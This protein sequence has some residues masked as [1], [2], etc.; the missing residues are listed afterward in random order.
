MDKSGWRTLD[1]E[2]TRRGSEIHCPPQ[3]H[4]V[5]QAI[6]AP[7]SGAPQPP[8][9][10]PLSGD[11]SPP[12]DKTNAGPESNPPDSAGG[13]R[14]V[15]IFVLHGMGQQVPFSTLDQVSDK[16]QAVNGTPGAPLTVRSVRFDD[17]RWLRR[18]ELILKPNVEVHLYEGYWAPFTEG[19]VTLRQVI[20]F[21]FGAA[22]NGMRHGR[23]TFCRWMFGDYRHF[24]PLGR[25]T[26]YLLIAAAALCSLLILDSTI[27]LVSAALALRAG[28]PNWLSKGLLNDLT[29]VVN[30]VLAGAAVGVLG[31]LFSRALTSARSAALKAVR[32]ALTVIPFALFLAV[33]IL[34][35][36][37]LIALP[38]GHAKSGKA[39]S[40]MPYF[41]PEFGDLMVSFL[42][43]TVAIVIAFFVIRTIW[44]LAQLVWSD[45]FG[46]SSQDDFWGRVATALL[47]GSVVALLI[48]AG[49]LLEHLLPSSALTP[50]ALRNL[51][52]ATLLPLTI[53]VRKIL[54]QFVGDVAIYVT[55]YKLDEFNELRDKIRDEMSKSARCVYS[56]R[57]EAGGEPLY[58]QVYMV[59]HSL[60]SV[61]AYDI[62]NQLIREDQTRNELH[63]AERTPL[64][65]TFGSP[66]DKTAFLFAVQHNLHGPREALAS[67]GQPLIQSYAWRPRRWVNVYSPWDIVSGPLDLFD[68]Q[69]S[70]GLPELPERRVC[71]IKDPKATALLKA[72]VAYWNTDIV[73]EVLL[74]EISQTAPG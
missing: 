66:L 70:N 61:I 57:R 43:K 59:G 69:P 56:L 9:G 48:G 67:A 46:R 24:K 63:V 45:V 55:P 71:N 26:L 11:T 21:L 42:T 29:L 10:T 65:L 38:Y 41:L 32:F 30:F 14:K 39:L 64:L 7:P 6:Q 15:A 36:V 18:V 74:A 62:L 49:R 12:R 28:M 4:I 73:Y 8:A 44:F 23:S 72:H 13:G 5:E 53:F 27:A 2:P 16:L 52:W 47:A 68:A 25:T 60:G 31:Y 22:R 37:A 40:L 35:G 54:V 20:A 51:I 33:L 34:A 3:R 1:C 58:E 50:D 19:R 17:D